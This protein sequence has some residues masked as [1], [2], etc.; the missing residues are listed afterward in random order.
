MPILDYTSYDEVRAVLG[1]GTGELSDTT[2]GLEVY[3]NG[4][5]AELRDIKIAGV[6]DTVTSQY[7]T[8][9]GMNSGRTDSQQEFYENVRSFSTYSIARSLASSLPMFAPKDISES[10]TILG[11]FSQDPYKETLKRI[12]ENYGLYRTR[13]LASFNKVTAANSTPVKRTLFAVSSPSSDRVTG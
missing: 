2:L 12:E 10:K 7:S 4:L 13:L 6:N 5:N 3:S 9:K 8:I 1:V 11:R